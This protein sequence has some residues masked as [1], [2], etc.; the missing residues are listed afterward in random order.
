M[1]F[2]LSSFVLVFHL[3]TGL[4][5]KM[6]GRKEIYYSEPEPKFP[7]GAN[8]DILGVTKSN[9]PQRCTSGSALNPCVLKRVPKSKKCVIIVA[10]EN[11]KFKLL[12]L[13]CCLVT[14]MRYAILLSFFTTFKPGDIG[15]L[16]ILR[17]V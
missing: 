14:I 15:P 7:T 4:L 11:A 3:G 1:H 9:S 8:S 2:K 12:N 5:P 17:K 10:I 16:D 6:K 13:N